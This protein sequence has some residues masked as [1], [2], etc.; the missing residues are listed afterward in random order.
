MLASLKVSCTYY[1]SC[2]TLCYS[3]VIFDIWG[4]AHGYTNKTYTLLHPESRGSEPG[5]CSLIQNLV[6]ICFIMLHWDASYAANMS[7]IYNWKPEL[8]PTEVDGHACCLLF[9]HTQFRVPFTSLCRIYKKVSYINLNFEQEH[10]VI[11]I[12]VSFAHDYDRKE[13]IAPDQNVRFWNIESM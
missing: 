8:N 9:M 13:N 10:L 7:Y 2:V 4:C 5:K 11:L 3:Y 12:R 1:F 6:C